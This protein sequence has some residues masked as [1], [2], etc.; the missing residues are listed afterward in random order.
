MPAAAP[1]K[2]AEPVA[3]SDRA[4]E[5]ELAVWLHGRV[6]PLATYG[7]ERVR[8][9]RRAVAT[10]IRIELTQHRRGKGGLAPI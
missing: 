9:F 3:I 2:P 4:L 1:P 10:V 5:H 7:E 6:R 8:D